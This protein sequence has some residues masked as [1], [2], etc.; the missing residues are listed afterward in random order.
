MDVR[1]Q[2][3]VAILGPG[4]VPPVAVERRL[5]VPG[6]VLEAAGNQT[7]TVQPVGMPAPHSRMKAL[8]ANGER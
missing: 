2:I 6:G 7:R 3:H 4:K 8:S 5:M 1:G